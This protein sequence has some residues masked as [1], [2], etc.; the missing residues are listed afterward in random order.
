MGLEPVI[1]RLKRREMENERRGR[2]E[3]GKERRE[4]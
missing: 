4:D 1:H 3:M 2:R